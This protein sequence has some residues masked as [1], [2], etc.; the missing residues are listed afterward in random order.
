[1]KV[2][3]C[4]HGVCPPAPAALQQTPHYARALAAMGAHVQGVT[5][6]VDACVAA[7]A[8]VVRRRIGPVTLNWLPRGPVWR[9]GL[10]TQ[11]RET[12]L[13][14]LTDIMPGGGIWISSANDAEAAKDLAVHGFRPLI[15][16]QSVAELDLAPPADT[17]LGAQHGKWRNRL[18]H[19]QGQGLVVKQRAFDPARDADFLTTEAAQ[20]RA[21]R[22]R[23]L[24]LGFVTA[25]AAQNPGAARIWSACKDGALAAQILI[26]HH[27]VTATYH[28]GHSNDLGRKT[29]A[30]NL[31]LWEAQNWL[32]A[33]DAVRL[34]LGPVY[35]EAA[36]GL[37]RFKQRSGA[38][39]CTLGPSM[40]RLPRPS[41]FQ[42]RHRR[43]A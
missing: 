14:C 43:V 19:A 18:R 35:D 8:L 33:R 13:S 5:A 23:A 37:A 34:D 1:M 42:K 2:N 6:R 16:P 31:L 38:E 3:L 32:A 21:R 11:E 17:R 15:A 10:S 7:Q 41:L 24:P 40:I 27:G 4:D 29:S 39:L 36:A 9:A 20:R 12:F 25:F 26:L 30:H 22:Y 28:I